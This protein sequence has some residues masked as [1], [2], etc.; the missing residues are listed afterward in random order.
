MIDGGKGQFVSSIARALEMC[1]VDFID[2]VYLL[3]LGRPVD[4]AGRWNLM[5]K[6]AQGD[7]R[8]KLLLEIATSEEGRTYSESVPGLYEALADALGLSPNGNRTWHPRDSAA[9]DCRVNE[10]GVINAMPESVT[11]RADEGQSAA[12]PTIERLLARDGADFVELAY[13]WLLGRPVDPHGREH[14]LKEYFSGESKI[15]IIDAISNSEEGRLARPTIVG[16]REA[17]RRLA[18]LRL[19]VI[20]LMLAKLTGAESQTNRAKKTRATLRKAH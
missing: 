2:S 14:Y 12:M 13:K 4:S 15:A 11:F 3:I 17:R 20:G 18:Q 8:A 6:L 5:M 16:L 19:P 9:L 1:D 10:V 7:S